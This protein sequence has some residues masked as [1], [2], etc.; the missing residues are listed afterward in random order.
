M[1]SLPQETAYYFSCQSISLLQARLLQVT[2]LS[3]FAWAGGSNQIALWKGGSWGKEKH[4]L[5]FMFAGLQLVHWDRLTALAAPMRGGTSREGSIYWSNSFSLPPH[6]YTNR[7]MA[8][9]EV[10]KCGWRHSY[11]WSELLAHSG[12][13]RWSWTQLR[14]LG[15]LMGRKV[16]GSG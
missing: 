16:E 14:T 5:S 10:V 13:R 2:H 4:G 12:C 8:G 3:G 7:S 15:I 9:S 11:C 1:M 6:L